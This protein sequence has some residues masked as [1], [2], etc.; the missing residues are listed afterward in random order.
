MRAGH[1]DVVVVLARQLGDHVL[2]RALLR[3]GHEDAC[4]RPGRRQR[5][6][7]VVG[8]SDDGDADDVRAAEVPDDQVLRSAAAVLPWFMMMTAS[9]PA[10]WAFT[11]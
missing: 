2:L 5:A 9:A 1:H 10:A 3:L 6:P 8:R 11:P 4:C 7:C